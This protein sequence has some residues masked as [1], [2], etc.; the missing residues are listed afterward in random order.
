MFNEKEKTTL[1]EII[2][3]VPK[4]TPDEVMDFYVNGGLEKKTEEI[5]KSDK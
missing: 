5:L 3:S 1:K 2:D 4:A